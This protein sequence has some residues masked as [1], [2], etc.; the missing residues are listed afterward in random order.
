M[1]ESS[2]FNTC[3]GERDIR[4]VM[5][6][7]STLV[8]K[9]RQ[10]GQELGVPAHEL[11]RLQMQYGF[12]IDQAFND[13]VLLWLRGRAPRTWQALV[14][15]VADPQGVND[16]ALAKKIAARHKAGSKLCACTYAMPKIIMLQLYY[17]VLGY[18]IYQ[19]Y[20]PTEEQNYVSGGF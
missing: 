6:E 5:R 11:E 15:A 20:T 7:I 12:N 14:K 9:Y 10:L 18:S 8:A 17:S 1:S 16:D 3:V 19:G 2:E 4:D 13:M